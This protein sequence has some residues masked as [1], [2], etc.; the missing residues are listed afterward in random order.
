M[1]RYRASILGRETEVRSSD[2]LEAAI[3]ACNEHRFCDLWLVQHEGAMMGVERAIYRLLGLSTELTGSK[4]HILS[5]LESAAASVVFLDRD[6]NEFRVRGDAPRDAQTITFQTEDGGVETVPAS[7]CT[8][9]EEG[10][11]AARFFFETGKRPSWLRYRV[12][13]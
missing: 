3:A 9:I 7:E 10:L 13:K 6:D 5:N 12:V 1:M 2:D 8:S 4:L 11:R